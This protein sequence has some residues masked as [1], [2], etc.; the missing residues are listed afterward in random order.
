MGTTFGAVIT[1]PPA[2]TA[3]IASPREGLGALDALGTERGLRL[4][5]GCDAPRAACV[6]RASCLVVCSD[7][8]DDVLLDDVLCVLHAVVATIAHAAERRNARWPI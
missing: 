6:A 3:C 5:R 7:D 8:A 2:V 4:W 1:G